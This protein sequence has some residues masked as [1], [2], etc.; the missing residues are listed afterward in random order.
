[1]NKTKMCYHATMKQESEGQQP[2][3]FI[4]ST[5]NFF[6]FLD[7][8]LIIP[9]V[10]LYTSMLGAGPGTIGLLIGLYSVTNT[11]MNIIT[12]RLIDR[13]GYKL[14][15][16]IGLAGSAA[17]MFGYSLTRLPIHLA[18]VRAVH[19]I[20]GGLKAPAVMAVFT[21]KA[22]ES[23]RGRVMSFYGMS[24]A[25]ANLVGFGLSGV[26]VSRLGYQPLF[27][28]GAAVLAV[29][30]IVGLSIPKA[31]R[32]NNPV[33]RASF[34]QDFGKV[35]NLLKRRGLLI[36]LSA[37]FA[38]YFAF[39]GIVTLLPLYVKNQG[40]DAFHVGM[41]FTAFT[42]A[43]IVLQFPSGILSDRMGRLKLIYAGL[44]LG[45]VTLTVLPLVTTFAALAMTM[46]LYGAAF[47]LLFPSVSAMIADQALPEERGMAS[48][49]FHALLTAGVAIGAPIIGGIGSII[50]VEMGLSLSPVIL[51]I[52][53]V[54]SLTIMRR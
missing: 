14:P 54:M 19:G 6:S 9:I 41:L 16:V 13:V 51:V 22:S 37:I 39:G 35:R 33:V 27:L 49:I 21:E 43:F 36:S 23:Q 38:Q 7:V 5:I 29:G 34:S 3:L 30:T 46:A 8:N 24:L 1:M 44:S 32:Q 40:M 10:A 17:S 2:K 28:F 45:I 31:K 50:G 48:G 26:I 20:C 42:I 11:P 52:A 47:G 25:T 15:L 4:I 53:L 18:I 12:G